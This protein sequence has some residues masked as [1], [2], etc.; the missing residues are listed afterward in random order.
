MVIKGYK[1]FNKGLKA[2]DD[3]PFVPGVIYECFDDIKF[4]KNGFH[5]CLN[6]ED[7][8]RYFNGMEEEVDIALVTGYAPFSVYEDEYNGYYDMY[9]CAKLSVDRILT[10]KEIMEIVSELP[11]A[12]FN[13]FVSGYRLTPEEY[14]YFKKKYANNAYVLNNLIYY[15]EDKTI[16]EKLNSRILA[17]VKND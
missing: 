2:Y 7:T 9:A 6:I 3:M 17:R 12:R 10:R 5:M 13:R 15:Y 4:G 8:L 1:C 16:Y 11:D 14:D